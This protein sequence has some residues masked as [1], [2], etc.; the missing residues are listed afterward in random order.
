MSTPIPENRATFQLSE[1]EAI[2]GG[3]LVGSDRQVCGITTDSRQAE[4]NTL[5]VAL[6][7]ERTD[8]HRYLEQVRGAAIVDRNAEVPERLAHVRV[9][10]TLTALG[11][12]ARAHRRSFHGP[13]VGITGSAGKTS[14]KTLT[15]AALS[16]LGD[17]FATPG[18]L[19]NRI[20]LPMSL[21]A[22][23]SHH[24]AA[25]IEMGTSLPG[26]IEELA[27]IAMPDV[28]LVTMVGIAHAEGLGGVEGIAVEKRA[29]LRAIPA[30]GAVLINEDDDRLTDY[31]SDARR[32]GFGVHG[33]DVRIR[34]WKI[35]GAMTSVDLVVR[36]QAQNV[37]THFLGET[38]AKNVAAAM[39]VAIS[40][41]IEP[42]AAATAIANTRPPAGRFA[43]IAFGDV[44]LVD[45][46]YNANPPSTRASLATA[47]TLAE[48]RGGR[49]IA[50]LGEMRELGAKSEESHRELRREA[51]ELCDVVHF[52]GAA[53]G[54]QS[55]NEH[56]IRQAA[57][58]VSDVLRASDVVLLKGSRGVRIERAIPLITSQEGTVR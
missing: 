41:D 6:R 15:A 35:D 43:P 39:S 56:A 9:E 28:G 12:V 10:D 17:I 53:Y 47:K 34:A 13:V 36:G 54:V 45:D 27:R 3:E 50:I 38:A 23:E 16:P 49:L 42:A 21:L 58:C 14:T 46:T 33:M 29:L 7:G 32:I 24:A 11:D 4:A 22:L 55:D 40:L 57:G 30:D 18:N 25:V 20:G 37:R 2:T 44:L 51:E 1:L 31:Q 5:F 48:Q 8:G 26:E 19:N 52:V